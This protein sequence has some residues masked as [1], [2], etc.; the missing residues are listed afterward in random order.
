LFLQFITNK[1]AELIKRPLSK[2]EE[3]TLSRAV[4]QKIDKTIKRGDK[5][6]NAMTA[7]G[8]TQMKGFLGEVATAY[9]LQLGSANTQSGIYT[10]VT[11][12]ERTSVAGQANFDV[13]ARIGEST[14]GF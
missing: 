12:A 1:I 4:F 5:A 11:G 13:A 3:H 10:E 6:L 2:Q 14:I 9:S 7:Y 8:P